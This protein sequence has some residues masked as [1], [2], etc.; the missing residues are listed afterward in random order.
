MSA[1]ILKDL[2]DAGEDGLIGID[3]A[4]DAATRIRVLEKGIRDG[5]RLF[6]D[7]NDEEAVTTLT[8]ALRDGYHVK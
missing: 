7:L 4:K 3:L 8:E 2:D 5:L 1:V 6:I